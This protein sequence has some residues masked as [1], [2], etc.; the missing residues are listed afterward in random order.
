MRRIALIEPYD[1]S[2]VLYSLCELLLIQ[3]EAKLYIFTQ[4]Y[5]RD[6][7]PEPIS[8]AVAATWFTFK[9]EERTAFF[10]GQKSKLNDCDLILWITAVAPCRWILELDLQSPFVLIL[11]NRNN[12]FAPL[13]NWCFATDSPAAFIK[14]KARLFRW[15]LFQQLQQQ[16]LLQKVTAVGYG[17]RLILE[18]ALMKGHLP[19]SGKAFW[20]PFSYLKHRP[21][22][23]APDTKT[24]KIAIPG[25]VTNNGR[26]YDIVAQ[27]F[28]LAMPHLH[29]PVQLLLLGKMKAIKGLRKLQQLENERFQLIT[30]P[31]WI[32]QEE[33]AAFLRG[34]D[35]LILPFFSWHKVGFVKEYWG[36]SGISGAVSD[37]V[38]YGLSALCSVFHPLDAELENWVERYTDRQELA[39]LLLAWVN[40]RKYLEVKKNIKAYEGNLQK[41]R[42]SARLMEELTKLMKN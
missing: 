32:A 7:A 10:Q 42:A 30:F 18:E 40:E 33:Y 15:L 19:P 25:V 37:M 36:R 34:A 41:E 14:D 16:R 39:T 20:T 8:N 1:H 22:I 21:S 29:R 12:W 27:A 23:E 6:H 3:P 2:E 24:V 38:Y 31:H 4:Q 11:H 5:I 26:D 28:D 9:P 17:S 13:N 35:F